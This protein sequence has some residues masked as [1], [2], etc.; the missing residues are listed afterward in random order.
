MSLNK[1][2]TIFISVFLTLGTIYLVLLSW[3]AYKAHNYIGVSPK[4]NH[5]IVIVGEG[6]AIGVPDIAKINLG[7]SVEKKTVTEAQKE[8]VAKM[9]SLINKL[10]KDFKINEQD[11]KTTIYTISS[12]YDYLAGGKQELRGYQ[13][14]QNLA[15]KVRDINKVSQILDVAS[16]LGIN[17]VDSMAFEIDNP[18]KLREEARKKAIEQA[19]IKADALSMIANVKIGKIISFSE[20]G[21]YVMSDDMRGMG[22]SN[23]IISSSIESGSN[24]IT[25]F[26]TVE[27]EI[28]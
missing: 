28:L 15:I 4:E 10:K 6:K 9:S 24:E 5:S 20:S 12:Q 27:Y 23:A 16:V 2:V 7:Y 14:Y 11:I 13:V 3:N 19:K 18:E 22:G 8:N 21:G 26:A 17:T 1:I 25:I